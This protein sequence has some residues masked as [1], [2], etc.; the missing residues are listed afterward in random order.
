MSE[1]RIAT[2]YAKSL[3]QLAGDHKV[4]EEVNHDMVNFTRICEKNREF[5]VML[6]NPIIGHDIKLKV[7]QKLFQGKFNDVTMEIFKIIARKRRESVLPAIAKE[8]HKQYNDAKGIQSAVVTTAVPLDEALLKEVHAL[9]SRITNKKI[10]LKQ[11]VDESII[12]GFKVMVS[13]RQI[14]DTIRTKLDALALKFHEQVYI[15]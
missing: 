15:D 3:L 7:F 12:G 5:V 1:T 8:F 11:I 14:D 6:K 2:R 13:D 9:L 4:L 10:D